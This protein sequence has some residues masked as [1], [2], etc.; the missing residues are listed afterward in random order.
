[1]VHITQ[2]NVSIVDVDL[3]ISECLRANK[4]QGAFAYLISPFISDFRVPRQLT[5][6]ASNL[7]N[8]T[9]VESFSDL[10]SLLRRYGAEVKVVTRSPSDLMRTTLSNSFVLGQ[11]KFLSKVRSI[12]CEVHISEK[13]HAKGTVTSQGA[14]T[15][16]FNL[17]AS[18]RFS[19]LEEGNLFANTEG[20]E[21]A[22]YSEKLEWA[23]DIFE[24]QSRSVTETDLSIRRTNIREE[25]RR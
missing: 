4:G 6:F 20:D 3:I 2:E 22:M 18:G 11:A 17:T 5:K 1:M 7:V 24:N 13:L 8:V 10:V 19:N 25:E 23:K 21:K 9:D 15:G 16:S 14:L 12:G